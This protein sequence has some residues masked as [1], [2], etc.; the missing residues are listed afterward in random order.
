MPNNTF[1]NKTKHSD[2]K[3]GQSKQTSKAH[4]ESLTKIDKY[5]NKVL[6]I[7]R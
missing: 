2:N 4:G 3:P 6:K 1:V 7:T 5:S